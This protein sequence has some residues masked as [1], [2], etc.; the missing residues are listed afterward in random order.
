MKGDYCSWNGIQ[1][2][3]N[4]CPHC[5]TPKHQQAARD[6]EEKDKDEQITD[7][8]EDNLELQAEL[9]KYIDN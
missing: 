2:S 1:Y 4:E 7:L 3:A 9:E 8:K 6:R 5:A